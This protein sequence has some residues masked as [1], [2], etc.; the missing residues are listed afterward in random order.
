MTAETPEARA[1]SPTELATIEF[2]AKRRTCDMC[3]CY[4]PFPMPPDAPIEQ[5]QG[6]C[7]KDPPKLTQIAVPLPPKTITPGR[8]QLPDFTSYNMNGWPLVLAIDW[9]IEG[10]K[11]RPEANQ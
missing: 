7:R 1:L 10:F 3:L 6:Q 4:N 11:P 2:A 9:C 8:G 5:A